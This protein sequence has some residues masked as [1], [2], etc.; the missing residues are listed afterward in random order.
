MYTHTHAQT[1]A[2]EDGRCDDGGDFEPIETVSQSGPIQTAVPTGGHD[3]GLPRSPPAHV[4]SQHT[5]SP[6]GPLDTDARRHLG[7]VCARALRSGA[8]VSRPISLP[9]LDVSLALWLTYY[10]RP[11]L[12]S[13]GRTCLLTA[14]SDWGRQPP[15]LHL[16]Y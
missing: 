10:F 7:S 2:S 4:N 5:S 12:N 1:D 8:P 13:S 3:D 15:G 11:S 14:A 6:C 9:L 16:H